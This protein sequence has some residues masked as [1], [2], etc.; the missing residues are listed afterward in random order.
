[1][2]HKHSEFTKKLLSVL[3]TGD[4]NPNYGKH[5]SD[6]I[7]QKIRNSKLRSHHT[8]ETKLKMREARFRQAKVVYDGK[9]DWWRDDN[10]S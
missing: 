2:G 8:A 4:K 9:F 5:C 6:E 10:I 7:K 1:M 3:N